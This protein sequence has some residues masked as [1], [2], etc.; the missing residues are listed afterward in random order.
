MATTINFPKTAAE[1]ADWTPVILRRAL[2]ARVLVVARTRIEGR[3][4]AYCD[5]VPGQRHTDEFDAVLE[6]GAKVQED[7]ARAL[8]P[9]FADV[10][11]AD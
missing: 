11:Y 4:S 6:T 9:C 3:W 1:A 2:S 5:A 7:V 8:F 10:P